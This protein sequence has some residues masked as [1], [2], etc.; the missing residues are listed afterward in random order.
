MTLPRDLKLKTGVFLS[1]DGQLIAIFAIKY[2]ASRNVDWAL[3][4]VRRNRIQPVLAVR[5]GN[6][7][8]GLLKR[9][10]S[11]DVK[12][13]YPDVSTRLAL[14][15]L[16]EQRGEPNAVIYRE[17][18]MPFAETVIGSRRL[19]ARRPRGDDPRLFR[20]ARGAAAELLSDGA[21]QH[22]FTAPD[23]D[24]GVSRPVARAAGTAEWARETLLRKTRRM[25]SS[26][27]FL[28]EGFRSNRAF[29]R[30]VRAKIHSLRAGCFLRRTR[31]REKRISF[32]SRPAS[33]ELCEAYKQR[34]DKSSR[35]FMLSIIR[36]V[37]G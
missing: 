15:E 29:L 3:R 25:K 23:A 11:F 32:Y 13:V 20:R 10:F 1:V 26:A 30:A 19:P 35:L 16:T 24:A 33:R 21:G 5:E 2:Q 4:A 14:S 34:E 36:F 22:G 17:G 31:R 6:V 7:T 8:P 28:V 27:S 37:F 9:K 12:P 18:L